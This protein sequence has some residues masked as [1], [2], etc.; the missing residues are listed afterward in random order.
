[1]R[2]LGKF[3]RRGKSTRVAA[4][5]CFARMSM[6]TPKRPRTPLHGCPV[7]RPF[8]T[9]A[10]VRAYLAEPMIRCLRCGRKFKSLSSH[11]VTIHEM[12]A[13]DYRHAYGIPWTYGLVST[14]T[15][16]II[17]ENSQRLVAK[18]IVRGVS[19]TS[20]MLQAQRRPES[21]ARAQLRTENLA[22]VN[23]GC[24]GEYTRKRAMAPKRGTPEYSAAL[25]ARPNCQSPETKER[26][27]KMWVG[28]KRNGVRGAMVKD[29]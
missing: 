29:A 6:A 4:L 8:S 11:L 10:E 21:A 23:K 9:I 13:D 27:R 18:G 2:R 15:S 12:T 26:L 20:R 5:R 19:D 16:K 24:T 7:E 17:S 3:G 1:M 22:E 28:K 25:R 14:E